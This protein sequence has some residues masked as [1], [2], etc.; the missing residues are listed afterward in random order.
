MKRLGNCWDKICSR[1]NIEKA[2]HLA[3]TQKKHRTRYQGLKDEIVSSIY[4]E[5]NFGTYDFGE[6]T[7]MI[8]YEP[9][10][11]IIH[12]PENFKTNVYHKCLL[13]VVGPYFISKLPDDSYASMKG[14]GLTPATEKL[15]KFIKRHPSWYYFQGDISKYFQSIDHDL[16][17]ST[18]R[19]VLKCPKTL[20]FCD[21]LIDSYPEGLPIGNHTSPYFANLFIAKLGHRIKEVWGAKLMLIYMD[22]IVV[23]FETKQEATHFRLWFEHELKE[24]K[25][26]LKPNWKVAPV[27]TGI[28][29]LGYKFYP[30]HTRLRKRIKRRMK[31]KAKKMMSLDDKEFKSQMASYYGWCSHADCKHLLKVTFKH[32]LWAF[33]KKKKRKRKTL[34]TQINQETKCENTSSLDLS[35]LPY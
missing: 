35:V 10:K 23:C 33:K 16:L 1:E 15:K 34:P 4:Q 31:N 19:T 9:K 8:V 18:L 32:H 11:R 6:Y 2:F 24:L 26:A 27:S 28:D 17:K 12:Y 20:E 30:T 3:C 25:L 5:L 29:F 13:N 7:E 21:K 14:R 22:D